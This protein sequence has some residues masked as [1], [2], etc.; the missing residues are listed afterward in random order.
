MSRIVTA[1]I[2]IFFSLLLGLIVFA[3]FAVQFPET[4]ES[5]FDIASNIKNWLSN[6]QNTGLVPKYN[7]WVKF[8]IQEQTFVL[9]FFVFTSRI[10][11][12]VLISLIFTWPRDA[13][14]KRSEQS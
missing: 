6:R 11:L 13:I 7:V 8:L 10:V 14:A 12:A 1:T 5:I 3:V 2:N 4:M 9:M